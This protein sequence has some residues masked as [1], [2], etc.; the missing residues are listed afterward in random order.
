MAVEA[1]EDSA[2]DSESRNGRAMGALF[3]TSKAAGFMRHLLQPAGIIRDQLP[4][5]AADEADVAG[6]PKLRLHRTLLLP[7]RRGS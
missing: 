2:A 6:P 7:A 1:A 3:T 5:Q 4:R